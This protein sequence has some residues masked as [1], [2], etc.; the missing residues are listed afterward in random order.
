MLTVAK[1]VIAVDFEFRM[2]QMGPPEI[3][4]LAAISLKTGQRWDYWA[5]KI[6]AHPPFS[7]GPDTVY[8]MHF[9]EAELACFIVL[10]WGFPAFVFDTYTVITQLRAR[11]AKKKSGI[12]SSQRHTTTGQVL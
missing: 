10:G 12:K 1:D 11:P 6:P 2:P 4:C 8:L 3:R 7:F 5:G 9:G